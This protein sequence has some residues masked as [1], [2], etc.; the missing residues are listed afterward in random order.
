[1]EHLLEAM[2]RNH[3]RAYL[4]WAASSVSRG[5]FVSR[6]AAALPASGGALVDGARVWCRKELSR[7]PPRASILGG[8]AL[9]GRNR[10]RVSWCANGRYPRTPGRA[11][12]RGA[13]DLSYFPVAHG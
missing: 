6:W 4:F 9:W 5:G 11:H 1:V 13:R 7:L 2:A 10:P 12:I 8:K 3:G